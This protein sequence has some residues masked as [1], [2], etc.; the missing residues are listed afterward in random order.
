M[1][2]TI[3][4]ALIICFCITTFAQSD[5][6]ASV[7]KKNI[8]MLDSAMQK[9]NAKELANNFE[10]IGD[11]EK[12]Q[13]LPYY[14][15]AYANILSTY[16]GKDKSK[17]DAIADKAE[18]LIIKAEGLAGKENSETAVI[19]SMIASAHMMVDPQSRFMQ[20]GAASSENMQ[21]AQ[22]LDPENPRAVYLEAQA[23]FYTPAAFGGGKSVAKP[24]F[25]KAL[26]MFVTFKP[27][28]ELH[29]TWG[30]DA[31]EYFLAMANK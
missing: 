27:A 1:K 13:W 10:R 7:M 15:A 4:S 5:K 19:K 11:A 6:Y 2:K 20:Y 23:K 25:E 28:S 12:L 21:R 29:P 14:Y 8:S 24:L 26:K 16:T 30:K 31:A 18:E 9:G 17:V 3:L 22:E